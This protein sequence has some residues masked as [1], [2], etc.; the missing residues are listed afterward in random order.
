MTRLGH[1][2]QVVGRP[3]PRAAPAPAAAP[4]PPAAPD[5]LC[6]TWSPSPRRPPARPADHQH[7][8][9]HLDEV[10]HP[11]RA[12]LRPAKACPRR[13]SAGCQPAAGPVRSPPWNASELVLGERAHLDVRTPPTFGTRVPVTGLAAIIRS[14]TAQ[15]KNDDSEARNRRTDDSASPDR[16]QRHQR[17]G[18][19]PIGDRADLQRGQGRGHE[20]HQGGIGHVGLPRHRVLAL[21]QP[22][23]QQVATVRRPAGGRRHRPDA[24]RSRATTPGRP[25]WCRRSCSRP[26]GDLTSDPAPPTA[27]R[28][29][30]AHAVLRSSHSS[31]SSSR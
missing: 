8:H 23:R 4:G 12:Q 17:P 28:L 21:L 24:A 15:A 10:P 20:P 27:R 22:V 26:A 18:D 29:P 2:Q 7:R 19:L 16:C 30:D 11:N 1:E 9:R 14:R 13:R 3:C 5:A 25:A 6:P 31:T